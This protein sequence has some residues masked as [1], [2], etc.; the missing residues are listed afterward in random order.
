[1]SRDNID[2]IIE[3]LENAI[4]WADYADA[5]FKDR[6]DFDKDQENVNKA[7]AILKEQKELLDA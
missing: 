7:I 4:S 5:Y 1:M 2:F 6:H 3:T